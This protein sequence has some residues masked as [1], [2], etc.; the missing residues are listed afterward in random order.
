MSAQR[1]ELEGIKKRV[2]HGSACCLLIKIKKRIPLHSRVLNET[3]WETEWKYACGGTIPGYEKKKPWNR[4]H[5]MY[6]FLSLI[7]FEQKKTQMKPKQNGLYSHK[8]KRFSI[9]SVGEYQEKNKQMKMC[10]REEIGT[11]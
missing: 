5:K 1:N 4:N 10:A 6:I 11:A 3:K 8:L 9:F 7:Q 2:T